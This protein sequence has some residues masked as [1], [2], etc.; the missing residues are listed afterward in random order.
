MSATFAR[1]CFCLSN[2]LIFFSSPSAVFFL[3]NGM[4]NHTTMFSLRISRRDEIYLYLSDRDHSRAN[5]HPLVSWD[6]QIIEKNEYSQ[7]KKVICSYWFGVSCSQWWKPRKHS[8]C[9]RHRFYVYVSATESVR[10]WQVWLMNVGIVW[11]WSSGLNKL[12]PYLQA[13]Q[14]FTEL[15]RLNKTNS[16]QRRP[17]HCS[18][19]DHQS[20][21]DLFTK[22]MLSK[23][24][25]LTNKN[26][27]EKLSPLFR[28][29][30]DLSNN[31]FGP[32]WAT[33]DD[34]TECPSALVA[35]RWSLAELFYS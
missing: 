6:L 33:S 10:R 22:L 14:R 5:N 24:P 28:P 23:K 21:D 11:G 30:K 27:R 12:E 31:L 18:T 1:R 20:N 15:I 19:L 9:F 26:C 4:T 3:D 2:V 25:V 8:R 13:Q 17:Y 34:W 35:T 7:L 32:F 29:R 16:V